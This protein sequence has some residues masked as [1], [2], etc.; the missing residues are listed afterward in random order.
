ME[1]PWTLRY[2]ESAGVD[3]YLTSGASF[4]RGIFSGWGV[5]M[6]GED[7]ARTAFWMRRELINV[8]VL[9]G[10]I[11]GPTFRVPCALSNWYMLPVW[12]P[13]D[14]A[15]VCRMHA[16]LNLFLFLFFVFF[17]VHT[18]HFCE[19]MGFALPALMCSTVSWSWSSTKSF[20]FFFSFLNPEHAALSCHLHF[21]EKTQHKVKNLS[22]YFNNFLLFL[23]WQCVD[24]LLCWYS[25]VNTRLN[26]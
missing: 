17:F 10:G 3:S 26:S 14:C 13:C 22:I 11:D 12:T 21:T 8:E 16:G 5:F 2:L 24:C 25:W 15:D 20:L 9:S 6:A 18:V 23:L 1:G 7:G 4:L 19:S